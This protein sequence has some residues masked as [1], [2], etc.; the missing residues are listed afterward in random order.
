MVWAVLAAVCALAAFADIAVVTPDPRAWYVDEYGPVWE[1]ASERT[2]AEAMP[3]YEDEIRVY[4]ADGAVQQPQ[5]SS[6]L[7]A[8]AAN[9]IS[10]GWLGSG[11]SN[12]MTDRINATIASFKARYLDRYAGGE[13][14][15]SCGWYLAHFQDGAWTFTAYAEIDCASVDW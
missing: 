13:E 15:Y 8:V 5:T 4:G 6:W 14:S 2:A 12:V 7:E 10:E 9:W 11:L 1:Q 3:F